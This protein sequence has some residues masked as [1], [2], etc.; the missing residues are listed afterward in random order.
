MLRVPGAP[1]PPV[2][3]TNGTQPQG[4]NPHFSLYFVPKAGGTHESYLTNNLL[5][6]QELNILLRVEQTFHVNRSHGIVYKSYGTVG[7]PITLLENYQVKKLQIVAF[8]TFLVPA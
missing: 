1:V 7:T 6:A 2:E 5:S 4:F 3:L 8:I